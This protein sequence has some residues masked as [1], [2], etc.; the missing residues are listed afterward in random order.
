MEDLIFSNF[1]IEIFKKDGKIFVR[2]D[3]GGI[4]SYD[5]ENEITEEQSI[6]AQKSEQDAYEVLLACEKREKIKTAE[7]N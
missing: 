1:S 3:S 4:A 5:K 6:M 2:Y 7:R